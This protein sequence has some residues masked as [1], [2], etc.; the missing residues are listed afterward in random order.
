M[1]PQELIPTHRALRVWV[2]H[3][4]Q[5]RSFYLAEWAGNLGEHFLYLLAFG[6][7]LGRLIPSLNGMSYAQF[8]GP[9]LVV[10]IA[11]WT[12]SY[13][14]TFGAYSRMRI[15]KTYEAMLSAPLSVGDIVLGDLLWCAT[16]ALIGSILMII[17]LMFFGLVGSPWAIAVLPII[18]LEG[19][20]FGS[21]GLIAAGLAPNF[22]FFSFH[23]SIV[24]MP[25]FFFAGTF[26]PLKG[27]PPWMQTFSEMLPLTHVVRIVRGLII[28]GRADSFLYHFSIL[29]ACTAVFMMAACVAV[30]RRIVD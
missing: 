12:S 13:E 9:G 4:V 18:F 10:S 19:L 30:N 26:F 8:I 24:V 7:G 27:L 3:L 1:I 25:M 21:L 16:R 17:V 5:Y 14:A 2:R 29:V 11:M 23:F 22:S 20:M 15:Q 6:Y 28:Y